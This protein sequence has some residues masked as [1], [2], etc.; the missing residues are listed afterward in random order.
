[1]KSY[2]TSDETRPLPLYPIADRLLRARTIIISKEITQK[3]AASVSAQLLALA[4]CTSRRAAPAARRAMS[5][6]RPRRSCG[7]GTADRWF[8]R[9]TGQPPERIEED[10]HRNFWLDAD[11]AI[12]YGMVGQMIARAPELEAPAENG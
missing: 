9:A 10:C 3:L 2:D 12:R 4:S 11:V 6:P 5:P 8:A 1:M 7:C